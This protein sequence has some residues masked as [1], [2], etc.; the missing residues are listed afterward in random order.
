MQN[1]LVTKLIPLGHDTDS[2]KDWLP[3]WAGAGIKM[4]N[5]LIAGNEALFLDVTGG[6]ITVLTGFGRLAQVS[7]PKLQAVSATINGRQG[8]KYPSA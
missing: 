3:H 6:L 5:L 4:K 2:A 8:E 7:W 1:H